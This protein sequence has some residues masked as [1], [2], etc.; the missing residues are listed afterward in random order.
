[1][2]LYRVVILVCL[3]GLYS[4]SNADPFFGNDGISPYRRKRH[5]SNPRY[6]ARSSVSR[7]SDSEDESEPL[8]SDKKPRGTSSW[9]KQMKKLKSRAE[10]WLNSIHDEAQTL[11]GKIRSLDNETFVKPNV[12]ADIVVEEII[13]LGDS[14]SDRGL[15]YQDTEYQFPYPNIY[16]DETGFIR[17]RYTN[18]RVWTD[19]LAEKLTGKV[20]VTSVAY[21]GATSGEEIVGEN[22]VGGVRREAPSM[23]EQLEYILTTRSKEQLSKSLVVIFIGSND[24]F[25][26]V[27]R[28][29]KNA[30][31]RLLFGIPLDIALKNIR[32]AVNKLLSSGASVVL[33]N[34]PE[35]TLL[36][37]FTAKVLLIKIT[38]HTLGELVEITGKKQNDHLK[39]TM[40]TPVSND[41]DD[42][43]AHT[44][45][46]SHSRIFAKVRSHFEKAS[47]ATEGV[48]RILVKY[49]KKMKTEYY[50]HVQKFT[51]KLFTSTVAALLKPLR[52][53][54]R[55]STAE[56]NN[57]LNKLVDN[58]GPN[59]S[60]RGR[61]LLVMDINS[62]FKELIATTEKIVDLPCV[63]STGRAPS[64]MTAAER[65]KQR[66]SDPKKFF[67]MDIVHPTAAVHTIIAENFIKFLDKKRIRFSPSSHSATTTNQQTE[68]VAPP[69][70]PKDAPKS[71]QAQRDHPETLS[72][73]PTR[74]NSLRISP[75]EKETEV[76]AASNAVQP[77]PASPKQNTLVQ[78]ALSQAQQLTGQ[79]S[80]GL[81][82][83][84][85]AGMDYWK[86]AKSHVQGYL[87]LRYSVS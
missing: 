65:A 4:F 37:A 38:S 2:S 43:D 52:A 28:P 62:Q 63:A 79:I 18:G 12:P 70:P 32:E 40:D 36:P 29:P 3:L 86:G 11:R 27:K 44:H 51:S 33:F 24:L 42:V 77:Q 8:L 66:C 73:R 14:L 80:T 15:L 6:S 81:K 55:S 83:L 64:A 45:P 53:M 54:L 59:F 35:F 31:E 58:D 19:I 23:L 85:N 61:R 82:G 60:Q 74:V 10:G 13:V 5:I 30:W 39:S 20:K 76:K 17:G 84:W 49:L 1:M 34:L 22:Q 71:S 75:P 16:T 26:S 21:I 69:V 7:G 78:S 67:F 46:G 87:P 9:S 57:N 25:I 47:K 56:F 41:D 72:R 48:M 68:Q 50:P